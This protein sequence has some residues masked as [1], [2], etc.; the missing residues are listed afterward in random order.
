M[1]RSGFTLIELVFVMVVIGVL[2]AIALPKFKGLRDNA[3]ISN[4]VSNYTNALQNAPASYLNETELSDLTPADVN[5]TNLLKI[6]SFTWTTDH[7]KGW[8]KVSDDRAIYYID[9][10][11]YMDFQYNN[12]GTLTIV[13][14]IAGANK[15]T[16]KNKL[17]QKLG[18]TWNGDYN[19]TTVNL[20]D[21]D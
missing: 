10:Y 2:A 17:T 18:F 8:R 9:P 6:P 19:T 12:A 1:R 16:L 3:N 4:L 20:V 15:D 5:I 7:Q 21:N 13:T 14:R 11:K